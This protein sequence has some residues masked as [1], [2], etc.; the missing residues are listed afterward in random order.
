MVNDDQRRKSKMK[1][2]IFLFSG[3][4]AV[5]PV[6]VDNG[7]ARLSASVQKYGYCPWAPAARCK[8]VHLHPL[9]FDIK[10]FC[11]MKNATTE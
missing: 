3:R 2:N 9:D 8:G 7:Y 10:I 1:Y 4:H 5:F 6:A 11:N